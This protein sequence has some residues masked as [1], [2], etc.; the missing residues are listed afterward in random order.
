MYNLSHWYLTLLQCVEKS[1]SV[2]V[3]VC[4]SVNICMCLYGQ[5]GP[6]LPGWGLLLALAWDP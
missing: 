4:V 2:T 3:S 1:A 5:A 6:L